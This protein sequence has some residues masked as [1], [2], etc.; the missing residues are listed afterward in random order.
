MPKQATLELSAFANDC[1]PATMEHKAAPA[2]NASAEGGDLSVSGLTNTSTA[3]HEARR[4]V[5][6]LQLLCVCQLQLLLLLL[7][8]TFR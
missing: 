8:V 1:D 4:V 5:S 6:H 7:L 2:K 3:K